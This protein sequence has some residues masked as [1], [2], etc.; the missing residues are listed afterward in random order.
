MI[1]WQSCTKKALENIKYSDIILFVGCVQR[2]NVTIRPYGQA[3]K[4]SPSQ[5]GITGSIPVGATKALK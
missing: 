1:I 4:T 3:V 2:V 5:G